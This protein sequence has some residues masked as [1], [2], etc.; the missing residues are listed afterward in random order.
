MQVVLTGSPRQ[1]IDGFDMISEVRTISDE[2][3]E[4]SIFIF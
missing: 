1:V 3:F 4:I 2:L